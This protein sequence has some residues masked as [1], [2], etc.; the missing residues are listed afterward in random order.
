MGSVSHL[1]IVAKIELGTVILR[2]LSY[3]ELFECLKYCKDVTG[4]INL[5]CD[6]FE[7]AKLE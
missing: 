1:R 6:I 3:G 2:E 4:G 5:Y 7:N